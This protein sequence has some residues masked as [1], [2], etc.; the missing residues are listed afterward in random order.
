MSSN[1]FS[2]STLYI[3]ITVIGITTSGKQCDA[4]FSWNQ[5]MLGYDGRIVVPN[6]PSLGLQLLKEYHATKLGGHERSLRTYIRMASQ[7]Y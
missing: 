3:I 6:H 7:F 5:Q 1:G 2:F 4:K